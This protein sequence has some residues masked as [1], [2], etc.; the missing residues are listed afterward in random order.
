MRSMSTLA[1]KNHNRKMLNQQEDQL[2]EIYG[3]TKA[4]KYEGQN[5]HT[6]LGT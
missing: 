3:V 5:I 1:L 2:D 4:I 6:E